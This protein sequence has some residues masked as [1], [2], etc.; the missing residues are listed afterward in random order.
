MRALPLV[1]AALLAAPALAQPLVV[2]AHRDV[3]LTDASLQ[4]LGRVFLGQLR[5]LG[6]V[7]VTPVVLGDKAVRTQ[8]IARLSGRAPQAVEEHFVKLELR[9]EGRWPGLVASGAEL[10]T[11]ATEA[12]GSGAPA[13]VA[14]LT[15]AEYL[16]LSAG[17]RAQLGALTIDGKAPGQPGYPFQP[18]VRVVV[19][20]QSPVTTLPRAVVAAVFLKKLSTLDDGTALEPLDQGQGAPARRAFSEAVLRKSVTAVKAYWQQRIFQGQAVPPA[21]KATDAEVLQAVAA[22]PRA[23]GYVSGA[24]K[25]EGVREVVLTE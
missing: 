24:V 8:A 6:G 11:R 4:A 17:V 9:A 23:I 14:C 1:L 25:L 12:V 22:N 19:S 10:L 15:H 13:V 3:T 16:G 7:K 2:V 20:S 5:E 18:E 21:E